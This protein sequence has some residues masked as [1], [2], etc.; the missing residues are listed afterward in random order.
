MLKSIPEGWGLTG[1][2]TEEILAKVRPI[3]RKEIFHVAVIGESKTINRPSHWVA[4]QLFHLDVLDGTKIN[5]STM[6][7]ILPPGTKITIA[8]QIFEFMNS[9][10]PNGTKQDAIAVEYGDGTTYIRI[11]PD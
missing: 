11:F 4:D 2:S 9:I 1:D 10:L 7:I 8:I 6:E 3:E 5:L